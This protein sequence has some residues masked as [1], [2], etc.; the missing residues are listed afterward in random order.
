MNTNDE[1]ARE[2]KKRWQNAGPDE[3][4]R[5]ADD[6]RKAIGAQPIHGGQVPEKQPPLSVE[7]EDWYNS[8]V[9][10]K[11]K[12][13]AERDGRSA[14]EE[15]AQR[16]VAGR[17]PLAMNAGALR[18]ASKDKIRMALRAVYGR[19]DQPNINKVVQLVKEQLKTE[20]FQASK[21]M[22]Q[23]IA[24]EP[25][26]KKLRRKPGEKRKTSEISRNESS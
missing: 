14:R 25:E 19:A 3:R 8:T 24:N 10:D 23:D 21:R 15:I 2:Y 17:Y 1:A 18:E 4:N 6:L 11:P 12:D 22:I 7:V 13:R 9:G 20:G 5:L 26:F 16:Y